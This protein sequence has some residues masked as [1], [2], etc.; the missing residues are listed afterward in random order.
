ME[1]QGVNPG[2]GKGLSSPLGSWDW[3]KDGERVPRGLP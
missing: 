3:R 1:G 2:Y